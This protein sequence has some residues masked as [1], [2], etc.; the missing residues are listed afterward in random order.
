VFG[1]TQLL[2]PS[3][4]G[5]G[6][7]GGQGLTPPFRTLEFSQRGHPTLEV[8]DTGHRAGRTRDRTQRCIAGGRGQLTFDALATLDDDSV[9][10]GLHGFS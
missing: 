7:C 2:T 8:L 1:A 3:G 10:V 9:S 6:S 5:V 4:M